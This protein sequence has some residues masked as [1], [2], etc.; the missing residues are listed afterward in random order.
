MG[1][2]LKLRARLAVARHRRAL[3]TLLVGVTTA[4][5]LHTLRAPAEPMRE[6]LVAT[7]DLPG[8][9][10]LTAADLVTRAWPVGGTPSGLVARP[11]GRV[12]AGPVR[13]GELL[14]DVRLAGSP[15]ASS[16]HAI[17]T[18]LGPSVGFTGAPGGENS[19]TVPADWVSVA[20]RLTDP[21]STLVAQPG[22][23]VDVIAGAPVDPL[24]PAAAGSVGAVNLSGAGGATGGP[25]APAGTSS[26]N[27]ARAAPVARG[28]LVL[29]VPGAAPGADADPVAAG[30]H[31]SGVLAALGADAGSGSAG[32]GH[33]GS[34]S[35]GVIVLA[36]SGGDALRLAAVEGVRTLTVARYPANGS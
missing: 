29:A 16:G 36:V 2:R 20:V 8:G 22:S 32:S 7:T 26:G 23:R 6:V 34:D 5:A 18:G 21:A 31:G 9:H 14:T 30:R 15:V 4:T 25:A 24:S 35:T 1:P 3:V 28:A 27:V 13:R 33:A 12:L 17:G 19:G 11:V 10:R